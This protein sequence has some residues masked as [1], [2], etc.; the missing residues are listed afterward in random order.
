MVG[1]GIAGTTCASELHR[2]GHDVEIFEMSTKDK[3][4]RPRQ[5]EGSVKLLNNVPAIAPTGHM[6]RLELHS[7]NVT[8]S[9][10]GDLGF[11]YEIGG[12][13]G[14]E[15]KARKNTEQLVPIHYS[16]RIENKMQLQKEF[17]VIVAAD[18][19]RS[20]IAKEAGLLASRLPRQ[21]GVGVGFTI[22]GDF[23]PEL[24]EVWVDNYLSFH[25]YSYVI[26]F[27]KHE[28]SLVSASIGQSINSV[29]YVTRLKELA[30][31]RDWKLQDSWFDFENWYDFSSYSKDNLYVI[32]SAASFTEPAFGFGLKW[33][34]QSAK[35]CAKAI[36]EKLDFNYLCRKELLSDFRSFEI[37]R[38][39][40]STADNDDY[41]NF[42]K[43]FNN[44]VV[45]KLAESGKS[46]FKNAWLLRLLFPRI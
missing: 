32:G 10:N 30:H 1:A 5:M 12:I 4:I 31:F 3:A 23:N 7:P 24:I 37:M 36:D 20:V 8:V 33:V 6:R 22:E 17:E 13:N 40:S 2:F 27:S 39:F 11:F 14:I 42:V 43:K 34:I 25:G 29:T 19:Y 35:L 46:L 9:F 26:P 45:K 44:P 28:A 18:G 41:D 16:T 15:A 38:R 21:I